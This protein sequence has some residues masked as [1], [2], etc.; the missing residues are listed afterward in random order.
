[1]ILIQTDVLQSNHTEFT[2]F[3][4]KATVENPSKVQQLRPACTASFSRGLFR[5]SAS[6]ICCNNI[7]NQSI[8][9]SRSAK[10][11]SF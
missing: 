4:G 7:I 11:K 9:S 6:W 2:L 8:I 1:M 3:V 5:Q 10:A